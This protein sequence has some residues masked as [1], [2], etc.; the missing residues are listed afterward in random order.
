MND[1]SVKAIKTRILPAEEI[2]RKYFSGVPADVFAQIVSAD[3]VSSNLQKHKLGKYAKWMLHLYGKN[4][5]K[6]EDLYKAQEYIPVF[7]KAVKANKLREKDVNCYKS[8]AEMY[9]AIEPFLNRKAI[10]KK[11]KIHHIKGQEAEKLYEDAVF[12]VIHPLTKAASCYYGKGTQWCTAATNGNNQFNRY[13]SQGKLYVI[14]NKTNDRKFQFHIESFSHVDETDKRLEYPIFETIEAT[15]GLIDFFHQELELVHDELCRVIEQDSDKADKL[16]NIANCFEAFG[17]H[18]RAIMCYQKMMDLSID[19]DICY[20][21][22]MAGVYIDSENYEMAI[23]YAKKS[24]AKEPD[25]PMAYNNMGL[26]YDGLGEYRKSIEYYKKSLQ[27]DINACPYQNMGI[28]YTHWGKYNKAIECYLRAFEMNPKMARYAGCYKNL[29]D[30][31]SGSGNHKQADECY[32]KAV[33]L[34]D[35]ASLKYI[36]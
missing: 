13:N 33:Q 4:R 16:L 15:S 28:T 18:E 7:D 10:S 19:E 5:L 12:T 11:E 24:L 26:A 8:L 9:V 20:Y 2:H 3:V 25:N 29:G 27:I 1:S 23:E 14:I 6:V 17:K 31:Y 35:S 22:N 30:A 32:R 21:D 34:G 36:K